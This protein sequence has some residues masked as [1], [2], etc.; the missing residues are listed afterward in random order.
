MADLD[1]PHCGSLRLTVTTTTALRSRKDKGVFRRRKC[2][3]CKRQ[4][5]TI[6]KAGQQV[7]DDPM[8][9]EVLGLAALSAM[10]KH[11]VDRPAAS[12]VN[13]EKEGDRG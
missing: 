13:A 4:F 1:C 3:R 11:V 6:E 7:W 5:S 10:R 2:V 12:L 8:A 9:H